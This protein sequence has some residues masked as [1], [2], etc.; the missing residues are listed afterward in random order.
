L[1]ALPSIKYCE[2][3]KIF[4]DTVKIKIEEKIPFATLYIADNLYLIDHTAKVLKKIYSIKEKVGPIITGIE[5]FSELKEGD[6]IDDEGLW[7]AMEF[8]YEFNQISKKVNLTISEIVVDSGS[9]KVFFN[10][11]P[12]ET[13]WKRE[14]LKSQIQKFSLAMK[15]IDIKKIPCYE[16][17]DFRFGEDIV[18]R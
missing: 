9:I 10:E 1:L 11:I 12:C 15:K 2:I 4:P 13:R 5:S 7:G 18:F 6:Y 14:E 8:W 17:L 16:Y 3:Q